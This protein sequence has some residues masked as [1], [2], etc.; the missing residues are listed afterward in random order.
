MRRWYI[1][2]VKSFLFLSFFFLLSIDARIKKEI[3]EGRKERKKKS[4]VHARDSKQQ[5]GEVT[6]Y[7]DSR[8]LAAICRARNA[9][10]ND[11]N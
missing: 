11:R 7:G 4:E 3:K 5:D 1:K 9:G 6:F 2:H 10:R 8:Y